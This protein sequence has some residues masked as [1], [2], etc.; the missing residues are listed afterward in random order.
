MPL[1]APE[2]TGPR[3]A[4]VL[5]TEEKG[6]DVNLA[7]HLVSDAYEEAFG[8]AVLITNDSD[9]AYPVELVRQRLSKVVG[10]LN[11]HPRPARALHHVASFY[12]QIREGALRNAQLPDRIRDAHGVIH[13]PRSW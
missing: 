9:L 4:R 8:A 13:R 1:A 2:V 5:K 3:T 6:S 7:S 12:K 10:I 11:P